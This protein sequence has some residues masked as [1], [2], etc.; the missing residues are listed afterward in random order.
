MMQKEKI[1]IVDDDIE[2]RKIVSIYLKNEG[3]EI[4]D[5]SDAIKALETLRNTT[6]DLIILDIMLPKMDGIEACLKIR[7]QYQMPIIF[8]SAKDED[9]DKIQGLMSGAEDYIT[10]PFNPLELMA[11]IKSQLRRYRVYQTEEV[12]QFIHEIG[13]L[14]VDEETR[15]V[16]IR[17]EEVRL[18]PKE[19]DIL[20]LLVRNKGKVFSVEKIYEMVWEDSF[21]KSDNTVMVHITKIREKIEE[22]PRQPVYLKTVWGVGY[23]V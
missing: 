21:Y 18:T 22:N 1:L 12:K 5:A 13:H 16:F 9:I 14:K 3:Y 11:R 10:K 8:L 23:R 17:N 20:S 2:I 19:F 15:Q 6:I 7:E 4:I